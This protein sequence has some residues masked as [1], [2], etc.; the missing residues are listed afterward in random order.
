MVEL[1]PE[2]GEVAEPDDDITEAELDR[3]RFRVKRKKQEEEERRAEAEK[4][5]RNNERK[6]QKEKEQVHTYD[7]RGNLLV[8]KPA[9]GKGVVL[10]QA[11]FD[12]NTL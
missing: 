12:V 9:P 11:G 5:K 4:E 6:K 10:R 3:M 2:G 1:E 7:H 8:V